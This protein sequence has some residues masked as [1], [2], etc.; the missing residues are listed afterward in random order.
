M[1]RHLT[2]YIVLLLLILGIIIVVD[3]TKPKPVDW[4]ETYSVNDKIPYGLYVFDKESDAL[5]EGQ[6]INKFNI[7]PYEFL[8]EQYDYEAKEYNSKGTFI[9][10]NREDD[11]DEESVTELIYYAEHGNTVFLSMK[12]FPLTL[13]DT[14]NVEIKHDYYLKDTMTVYSSN[15]NHSIEK[16][17]F[18]EGTGLGYFSSIDTLTTT[19]LGYQKVFANER[20]NYIHVPF[21]SGSFLLHMQ[22]AA[23]TNFYLLKKDNYKYAQE[24]L[25][26][27]PDKNIYWNTGSYNNERISGSPLRYIVKQPALKAALYIGLLAILVFII[28]NARRKQRI[29]PEISPLRNTTIDFA[30]TIG[31]LYYQEGN[32]HTI[33][34]KKIIYF[35]EKVRT[36]YLI[37]THQ[38]DEVFIEKLHHK[39][40]KPV[41]DIEKA[42]HLIKKHRHEFKSTEAD[43]IAINQAIEKLQL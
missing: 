20:A 10:I 4:R 30:K 22:P 1:N 32:H 23:F 13:L 18:K 19:V 35:L 5:F 24:V 25:S 15:E 8:D 28:F 37:D 12:S 38:L 21:G 14:L 26:Y 3:A 7:T 16:Y 41:E 43:V 2:I 42:V 40:G 33:I 36:E 34:E 27:I 11:I 6:E 9:N 17:Y 31:N 29:V 39:T